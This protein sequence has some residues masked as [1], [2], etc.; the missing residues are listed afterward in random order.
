MTEI[1]LASN[2]IGDDGFAGAMYYV[3]KDQAMRSL[4]MQANEVTVSPSRVSAVVWE[5]PCASPTRPMHPRV[6]RALCF[7]LPRLRVSC[8]A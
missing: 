3:S 8:C 7:C 4:Y 2:T 6:S 5:L 1:N